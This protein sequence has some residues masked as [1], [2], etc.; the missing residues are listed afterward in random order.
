[1]VELV[2]EASTSTYLSPGGH[3]SPPARKKSVT[4]R[5]DDIGGQF[6]VPPGAPT[7]SCSSET[8]TEQVVTV[9]EA[10]KDQ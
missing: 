1:M 5:V 9:I 2:E 4:L 10:F 6:L 3:V 7:N 8:L